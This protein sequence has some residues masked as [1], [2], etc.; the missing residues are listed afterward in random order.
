MSKMRQIIAKSFA[1]FEVKFLTYKLLCK[2]LPSIKGYIIAL[3][4]VELLSYPLF[5]KISHSMEAK[6][7]VWNINF[8]EAF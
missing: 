3:L 1:Y 5:L 7:D 2:R 8:V 4:K 6:H